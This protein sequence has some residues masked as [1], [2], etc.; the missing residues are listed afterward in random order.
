[1]DE[2]ESLTNYPELATG[3]ILENSLY[4]A[5]LVLWAVHFVAL[6]RS[7]RDNATGKPS[8]AP[9][10]GVVG[11]S[12]M[13]AGALIH[14]TTAE[15]SNRYVDAGSAA[16]QADIVLAWDTTQ[17]LFNALLVTGAAIVPVAMV[18]LGWS[19]MR[20]QVLGRV[21]GVA[22]LS[23]GVVASIGGAAGVVAGPD[24]PGVPIAVLTMVIFHALVGG[25]IVRS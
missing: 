16:E 17:I 8:L 21:S 5:A 14:V 15:F 19:L 25:R 18:A 7:A 12:V 13:A 10:V 4:L 1:M 23:L 9:V 20:T 11:L 22:A 24:S 2:V 6:G 3:R